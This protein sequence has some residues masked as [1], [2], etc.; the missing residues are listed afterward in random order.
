LQG[1]F[2]FFADGSGAVSAIESNVPGCRRISWAN[3]DSLTQ[4]NPRV[5]QNAHGTPPSHLRRARR[6]GSQPSMHW[7]APRPRLRQ[8]RQ[9]L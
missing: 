6:Q 3:G 5:E 8:P 7:S 2:A 4:G 1:N 9:G